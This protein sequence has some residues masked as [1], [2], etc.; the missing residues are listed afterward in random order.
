MHLPE[1]HLNK[2]FKWLEPY[3][4]TNDNDST[5]ALP[6]LW[7]VNGRTVAMLEYICFTTKLL[8]NLTM[9]PDIL[10]RMKGPNKGALQMVLTLAAL[11][12]AVT[13]CIFRTSCVCDL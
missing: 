3:E 6:R 2:G 9:S 10:Q 1:R 4:S 8:T 12:M 7:P 13:R 11:P 5:P